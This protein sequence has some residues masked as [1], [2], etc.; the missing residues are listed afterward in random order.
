ML[1][2]QLFNICNAIPGNHS[3]FYIWALGRML[4]ASLSKLKACSPH[5]TL[6]PLLVSVPMANPR[7]T[8]QVS[9]NIIIAQMLKKIYQTRAIFVVSL[10][11]Q[12]A[13]GHEPF[14]RPHSNRYPCYDSLSDDYP[15]HFS[16][17]LLV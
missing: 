10:I 15:I 1:V 17:A 11:L 3:S 5:P 12:S 14:V 9:L 7:M 13:A 2:V 4:Q 6:T 16:S 8:L